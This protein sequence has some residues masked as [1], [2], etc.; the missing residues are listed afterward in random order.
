MLVEIG[1][2]NLRNPYAGLEILKEIKRL[3]GEK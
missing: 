3:R 1:S 2:A